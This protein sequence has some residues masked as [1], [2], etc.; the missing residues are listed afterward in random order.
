[1]PLAAHRGEHDAWP[2]D[3]EPDARLEKKWA[4]QERDY[5]AERGRLREERAATD[6]ARIEA[7]SRPVARVR[8]G[9]PVTVEERLVEPLD[10]DG[11]PSFRCYVL[12][13]YPAT[14]N[15]VLED[16]LGEEVARRKGVADASDLAAWA[17]VHARRDLPRGFNRAPRAYEVSA[18]VDGGPRD[19]RYLGTTQVD[20]RTSAEAL[21]A[22]PVR[23]FAAGLDPGER[24]VRLSA[25]ARDDPDD[26]SHAVL[27]VCAGDRGGGRGQP[28]GAHTVAIER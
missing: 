11:T 18:E 1:M 23:H 16:S 3:D 19:R 15:A 14:S 9:R 4:G 28:V 2:R 26:R 20:A 6:D 7:C 13:H 24:A 25:A 21:R 12:K 17:E 10:A 5:R 22:V 27:P 8:V